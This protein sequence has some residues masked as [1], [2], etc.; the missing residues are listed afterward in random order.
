MAKCARGHEYEPGNGCP[1]CR[2]DRGKARVAA[3]DLDAKRARW[4]RSTRKRRAERKEE[5]RRRYGPDCRC[6]GESEPTFLQVDHVEG[7]GNEHRREIGEGGSRL[8][9]WLERAGWPGGFQILCAN[10]N[11]S[12]SILG[13]CAHEDAR[14]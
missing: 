14:H 5:A 12:K 8:L 4:L 7:G 11:Q 3:E 10:C 1:Q 9:Q 13:G 6:C 2:R